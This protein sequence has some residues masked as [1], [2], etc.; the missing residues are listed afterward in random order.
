MGERI[1]Y[2]YRPPSQIPTDQLHDIVQLISDGGEV[3]NKTL[4]DK[5]NNA[6]M[7]GY[8]IANDLIV[9]TGALKKPHDSSND[10]A[11]V[12]A[13]TDVKYEDY[14]YELGYVFVKEGHRGAF[15]ASRICTTL[16]KM[17]SHAN[18]YS[19][20]R[21]DNRVARLLI[22]R[23]GFTQSGTSFMSRNGKDMLMLYIRNA[24]NG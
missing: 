5:I 7:I 6:I 11:F 8:A 16:C 21:S 3:D 18:I 4:W 10:N 13:G 17:Y 24:Q 1:I 19:T 2:E 14:P 20:L 22:E 12:K 15:I 23:S 9:G